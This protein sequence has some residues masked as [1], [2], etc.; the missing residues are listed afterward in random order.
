[1]SHRFKRK[2]NTGREGVDKLRY[3]GRFFKKLAS[4]IPGEVRIRRL[5][6]ISPRTK[7]NERLEKQRELK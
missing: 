1:M 6:E 7:S 3:V 2:N 5:Q 4:T